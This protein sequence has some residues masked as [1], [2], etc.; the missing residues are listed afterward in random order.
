MLKH[1]W[2]QLNIIQPC[3]GMLPISNLCPPFLP[4]APSVGE[5][6]AKTGTGST[7]V[8]TLW[9]GVV[10]EY[11]YNIPNVT[12]S[13]TGWNKCYVLFPKFIAENMFILVFGAKPMLFLVACHGNCLTLFFHSVK[14]EAHKVFWKNYCDK[15]S[16]FNFGLTN[17]L[18]SP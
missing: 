11:H 5:L 7:L 8:F 18:S 6:A 10:R 12:E 3:C 4:L 16:C 17:L 2:L 15:K 9:A 1:Y 14:C 13:V